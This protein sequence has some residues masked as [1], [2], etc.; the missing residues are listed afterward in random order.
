M[1]TVMTKQDFFDL[2]LDILRSE[3]SY[4]QDSIRALDDTVFRIRG[5]AVTLSSAGLAYAYVDKDAYLCL[6]LIMPVGIFWSID[7]LF[8]SF[9]GKF[10]ERDR[11]IRIYFASSNFKQDFEKRELS[12]ITVTKTFAKTRRE[13]WTLDSLMRQ[14][15]AMMLRNVF[16]SYTPI[17]LVELLTFW[18]IN[19]WLS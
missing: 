2:S 8:K 19:N 13:G 12:G 15:S 18:L 17:I 7:G 11:E 16:F 1:G 5:W 14:V 9:Q 3:W 10:I 4:T 6:Y